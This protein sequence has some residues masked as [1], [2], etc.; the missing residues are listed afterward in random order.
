MQSMRRFLKIILQIACLSWALTFALQTATIHVAQAVIFSRQSEIDLGRSVAKQVEKQYGLVNDPELQARVAKIG[1]RLAAVSDRPD[2]PYTFKVLNG[3][4]INAFAAPGGPVYLFKGLADAMPSDE[5][6]AGIIGHEIGHIVKKHV[7]TNIER[8]MVAQLLL[9]GIGIAGGGMPAMLPSMAM[10]AV[11][12]GFSR[13]VEEQADHLSVIHTMRA[14]FNPYSTL[15]AM[16]KLKDVSPE[17]GG[18][19]GELFID[20]PHTQDRI[21]YIRDQIVN[22]FK[23]RPLA[24][25]SGKFAQVAD[26]TWNLPPVYTTFGGYKPLLRSY[27]TAG[28][29]FRISQ[30]KDYSADKFFMNDINNGMA[31]YYDDDREPVAVV[32]AEDARN[33]GMSVSDM[34]ALTLTRICEWIHKSRGNE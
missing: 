23:V 21:N 31:I 22:D 8:A 4:E 32:T 5:E 13:N 9:L 34:T 15:I 24:T 10:S 20:H 3:K 1:A 30:L 28:Q 16:E 17:K 11:M 29:I 7:L 18:Q 27:L 2:M 12:A 25:E 19:V 33:N 6:L 26:G 14:G